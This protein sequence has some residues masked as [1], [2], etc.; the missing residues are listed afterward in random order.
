MASDVPQGCLQPGREIACA[1]VS[2]FMKKDRLTIQKV[3]EIHPVL[4]RSEGFGNQT[5]QIFQGLSYICVV[6]SNLLHGPAFLRSYLFIRMPD[7]A[8]FRVRQLQTH[9]PGKRSV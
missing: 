1:G 4:S 7:N 3:I 5:R 9:S 8:K 6:Y 2:R